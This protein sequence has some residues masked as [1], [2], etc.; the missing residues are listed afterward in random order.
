VAAASQG[1]P[2]TRVVR[3]LALIAVLAFSGAVATVLPGTSA[4]ASATP[5]GCTE[6]YGGSA[7]GDSWSAAEPLQRTFFDAN[8]ATSSS[9]CFKLTVDKHTD[10]QDHE[11]ITVSWSGAHVTGG[12]SLNPY[13]ETGLAQ[14]YPV[15]LMECR[16]V[17]PKN[18][19]GGTVPS[20]HEAVSPETCWTN[21]YFQRT[22]SAGPG[23]GIWEQD[24]A[25]GDKTDH[26]QGIDPS[27]I[28]ASCNVNDTFDYAITP[29]RA[30]SG[31]VYAGCS[32]QAMP[33][34][35]TVNSVSIP[36][37]VYAFTNTNGTGSFPFEVRTALENQSLGC[38][39][40]VPCTLEVIPIDGINCDKPDP[41]AACNQTGALPPGQV[42][43]GQ[44][45]QDAVAPGFWASASN[46]DRRVPVPLEFSPPPSV[47]TV[48]SAGKPVPFYGS[49][50]LDQTALQWIPAYCLNK[51]RFNWQDN[52]MPDDA[53]FTLMQGGEAAAAEVSARGASDSGVGY[54]P[55]AATGWAIA[56]NIDKPNNAGQ[57]TTIRLDP[58][59]LAKLLTES[60]PGST[61]VAASHPGL[62]H[63]P[64]SLNLDPD[65]Y[66]LN[67]GLDLSHWS[68]AAA[69]LLANSTSSQVMYEVSSYIASDPKAMAF[70]NG[71]PEHDGPYTMRVNPA[72]RKMKLPVDS[73]P[74]LDTWQFKAAP[75]SCLKAQGDAMPPYM[76]LIAN[77]VTS[78]QLVAQAMLYSWPNV[79]TGCSGTG[80]TDDPYQ[81]GRV[82]PQGVGSRF[83]LG[84]VTLG[85]AQRYGL[86]TAQLQAAPGHYVAADNAGITAALALAT[87]TS[88]LRPFDLTQAGIRASTKAYPGAMV[89]YT[90]AKT[91]GLAPVTAQHVAQFIRVS[92]TEGQKPGRGNGQLAA[93]YVPLTSSGVTKPFFQQAQKVAR[94]VAAQKAPPTPP[95]SGPTTS[96]TDPPSQGSGPPVVTP[97]DPPAAPAP[98]PSPATRPTTPT[99]SPTVVAPVT[100]AQLVRTAAVTPGAGAGLMVGLL[101]IA[102]LAGLGALAGRFAL[103]RKGLR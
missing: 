74:Q 77:P 55:T 83:M 16:G 90:A 65:F 75:N 22:N 21:T 100:D 36:N 62:A 14:E 1:D 40:T 18:Y 72:Y 88:K 42:N 96:P 5:A 103:A 35:A 46:W 9:N 91:Y 53:A 43:N 51:Q 59:L 76:P 81:L 10:M 38:S 3:L 67:P 71:R 80:T 41:A 50:L 37:E 82:A 92:T 27:A 99:S 13:G 52:V 30:V 69:T 7:A 85:D 68:E 86:T 15:V 101:V 64:L 31:K 11:R 44:A 47:C 4:S 98:G 63:N 19:A 6:S 79:E 49:E 61:S 94:A 56:F 66:K 60:Y 25:N 93:G 48:A 39:S 97:S 95:T 17:D 87:P 45:P 33:P 58:L 20:G 8:G 26:I 73:W 28:P 2:V 57:Q 54:A 78:L 70:I 84:L 24:A 32:S 23:Q 12:R 102:A 29:F 89:V 34:E